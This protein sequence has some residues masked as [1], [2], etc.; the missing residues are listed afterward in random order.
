MNH[1]NVLSV[2]CVTIVLF[3]FIQFY[4]CKGG[5]DNIS[6]SG[7]VIKGQ[8]DQANQE[9]Q[10]G[11]KDIGVYINPQAVSVKPGEKKMFTSSVPGQTNTN[12]TWSIVESGGGK[13]RFL[14]KLYCAVECGN[15]SHKGGK[16][17][18]FRQERHGYGDGNQYHSCF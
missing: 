6:S 4:G 10:Q 8:G 16:Q 2:L 12:V 7:D 15:L 9:E 1:K 17:S 5:E 13:H 3:A 14:R 11:T 18:K